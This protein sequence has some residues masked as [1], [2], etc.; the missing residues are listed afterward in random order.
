MGDFILPRHR[1]DDWRL[2][3]LFGQ[4]NYLP[5]TVTNLIATLEPALTA[6][7]AYFLLHEQLTLIQLVGSVLVVASVI[8][9]RLGEERVAI[10][11]VD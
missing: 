10:A 11:I 6:I 3:T 9:L 2:R 7:W 8:L 1:S 4:L 5:A